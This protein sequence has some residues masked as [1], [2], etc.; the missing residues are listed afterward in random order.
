MFGLSTILR[1]VVLPQSK[2]ASLT[3]NIAALTK[4]TVHIWK[5]N[6]QISEI[7]PHH[8]FPHMHAANQTASTICYFTMV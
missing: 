8:K 4:T 1:T 7:T 3:K 6:S 5:N 2:Y